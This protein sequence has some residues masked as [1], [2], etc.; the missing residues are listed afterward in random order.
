MNEAVFLDLWK[1]MAQIVMAENGIICR[2]Y[3]M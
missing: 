1:E 3:D 2:G